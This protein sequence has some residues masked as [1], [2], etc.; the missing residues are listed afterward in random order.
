MTHVRRLPRLAH[1]VFAV[2]ART[3]ARCCA[4]VALATLAACGDDTARRPASGDTD[5]RALRVVLV[6]L[7]TLRADA[8]LPGEHASMPRLA[9]TAARG[10]VFTESYAATSSTQPSHASMF[11]GLNPWQHGLTRNGQ[12]L[13]DAALTLAER[14]HD[15][16]FET[17]AIVASFPLER[18]F[19]FTQGFD[20]YVDEFT[21]AEGRKGEWND[22]QVQGGLFYSLADTITAEALDELG[23]EH[24]ARRFVWVHYYD[25]HPPYGDTQGQGVEQAELLGLAKRRPQDVP[26]AL[27]EARALYDADVRSLDRSLA[28]LL[29]ALLDDP[30]CETHVL[31]AAD[32]GESFG[33]DGAFGHGKR[34]TRPQIHVPTVLLSPRV[35]PGTRDDTIGSVDVFAT[36]LDL[37]GLPADPSV[38]GR[39]LLL[40]PDPTRGAWGMRRTFPEPGNDVLVSGEVEELSGNRFY[41]ARNGKLFE[42]DSARVISREWDAPPAALLDSLRTTFGVF[43][44]ELDGASPDELLDPET[45]AALEALGYVR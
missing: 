30:S 45:R 39:S 33:D 22:E 5:A 20:R 23:R 21:V 29:D 27:V 24:G 4:L 11:T 26:A 9:A 2:R 36:L 1:A 10:A 18:R 13:P 3:S 8:F 40:P 44:R 28:T 31:L 37:A 25:P 41:H 7:D 32:H 43:E 14:L 6:T 42:G 16:G 38:A 35:Q 19:G 12:V 34:V 15:A 17:A